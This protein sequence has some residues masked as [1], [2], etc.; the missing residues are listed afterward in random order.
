MGMALHGLFS[1]P[2]RL[3]IRNTSTP[4]T[5]IQVQQGFSPMC[6]LDMTI[7]EGPL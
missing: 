2:A 4:L 3:S 5:L 6:E 7:R 1:L